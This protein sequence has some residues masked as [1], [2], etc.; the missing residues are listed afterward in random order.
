MSTGKKHSCHKRREVAAKAHQSLSS[1]E[2]CSTGA[3]RTLHKKE[4]QME[5]NNSPSCPW[6]GASETEA[7]V[8]TSIHNTGG[9]RHFSAD[10][11]FQPV[12][13]GNMNFLCLLR[14]CYTTSAD[15]PHRF[16][17]QHHG[18][19]IRDPICQRSDSRHRGGKTILLVL[20]RGE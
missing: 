4:A 16:V 3:Y 9:F 5:S 14:G 15:G 19:P 7:K 11:V 2:G 20:S 8:P 17:G 12:A 1:K 13:N 18:R 10:I 6:T